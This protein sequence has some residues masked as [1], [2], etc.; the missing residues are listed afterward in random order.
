M[1]TSIPSISSSLKMSSTKTIPKDADTEEIAGYLLTLKHRSVT[2]EPLS[3]DRQSQVVN[4]SQTIP[5]H[6][7]Y[8]GSPSTPLV[9]QA[10]DLTNE[11]ARMTEPAPDIEMPWENLIDGSKLVS[12]HDRDL[13][14]DCL[15]VAMAQMKPCRLQPADRVGCYKSR[16]VGFIGM[17]CKHC[18]GQ[19]GYGRFYP[20]SVRSLA[21]TTTSQTILKHIGVKC[22]FCPPE[23]R[24]AILELQRHQA[25]REGFP[26]G[27]PRYGS[28]KV[29]FQRIWGRLHSA[30]LVKELDAEEPIEASE[31]HQANNE[32]L[33]KTVPSD[34]SI[35]SFESNSD[36]EVARANAHVYAAK[37]HHDFM[38]LEQHHYAKRPKYAHAH[39]MPYYHHHL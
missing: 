5:D 36:D 30:E 11:E 28:R 22:R 23:I 31:E 2:P 21:Q 34:T 32:P 7:S 39:W 24:N 6:P 27:R 15:F 13:V 26:A 19:P 1:V 18:G 9:E 14:P 29:F 38:T 17:C 16:E 3:S 10:Q 35:D 8:Q 20:N 37:R 4:R 25:I 12:M 33:T